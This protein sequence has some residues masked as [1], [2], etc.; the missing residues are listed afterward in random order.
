MRNGEQPPAV[1]VLPAGGTGQPPTGESPLEKPASR[2]YWTLP[3][4][5]VLVILLLFVAATGE[6]GHRDAGPATTPPPLAAIDPQVVDLRSATAPVATTGWDGRASIEG[7]VEVTGV[8][9]YHNGFV[10]VGSDAAGAQAWLSGSGGGWRP[11]PMLETPDGTESRIQKVVERNGTIVA[12]GSVDGAIA[13]WTARRA[14]NWEYHGKVGAMAG[15][16]VVDL[17]AGDQLLAVTVA[18]GTVFEGWT[19]PDGVTWRGIGPIRVGDEMGVIAFGASDDW[20]FAAGTESCDIEPCRP[21]IYRSR[22]ALAWEPTSGLD[23]DAL[24]PEPGA[25]TGISAT[26]N[27]LIAVGSIGTPPSTRLAVWTS[28][29]GAHWTRIAPDEPL[30]RAVAARFDITGLDAGRQATATVA[31]DSGSLRLI[32]GTELVTDAGTARVTDIDDSGVQFVVDGATEVRRPGNAITLTRSPLAWFVAAEGP[33]IV[34]AGYLA[35]ARTRSPVVWSS[36]DSGATWDRAILDSAAPALLEQIATAGSHITLALGTPSAPATAYSEWD[37]TGQEAAAEAT[38][39]AYVAALDD[40]DAA[41]LATLL[42]ARLGSGTAATV[43][44]PALGDVDVAWWDPDTGVPDPAAIR[45]VLA[46][47][48]ALGATVNLE[49]CRATARL[50]GTDS[51]RVVC[52]YEAESELMDALLKGPRTGSFESTIEAGSIRTLSITRSP[53]GA[54]WTLLDAAAVNA[55]TI[56]RATVRAVEPSGE[57]RLQP[58]FTAASAAAHL[59]LAV[60]LMGTALH[61]GE[62]RTV[63]TA[64]GPM[65]WRWSTTDLRFAELIYVDGE[66]VGVDQGDYND[67]SRGPALWA[68]PD[69]S[70]WAELAAPPGVTGLYDLHPFGNGLAAQVWRDDQP[71]LGLFDGSEWSEIP[72]PAPSSEYY[73]YRLA[74]TGDRI[75]VAADSPVSRSAWLVD[76]GHRLE[77]TSLPVGYS[78][79]IL[80]LTATEE[81]FALA[82]PVA[83]SGIVIWY[84]TDGSHWE[85]LVESARL[86]DLQ[87][88]WNLEQHRSRYFVVGQGIESRCVSDDG[89]AT[90]CDQVIRLW[91]SPDGTTWDQVLTSGGESV[92]TSRVASG[93]FGLVAIGEDFYG[94]PPLPRPVYVSV[95][96]VSW[97]RPGNL[98]LFAPDASWWTSTPAVGTSTVVIP[99]DMYDDRAGIATGFLIVGHLLP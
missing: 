85:H 12:L 55:P 15:R 62:T 66:F 11:V 45:D 51:L 57:A 60:N 40:R 3:A 35:G 84:S 48:D 26:G 28:P 19:S 87:S 94:G 73:G 75:L 70:D 72:L 9:G 58:S 77:P 89:S 2:P 61:P 22:D 67:P 27:G 79:G 52:E 24:S 54:M 18:E 39:R 41:T 93:P 30:L 59:R 38:V 53:T 31:T 80:G 46:Y 97:E 23:P 69:G 37:T 47:L 36:A 43:Q 78:G 32:A 25:V 49:S 82:A 20:F 98:T 64:A 8:I 14:S 6:G 95:D 21:V 63:A 96:G 7:A 90:Y 29:D 68:S 5:S 50:G 91:S 74:S 88:L 33:R 34:I 71:Y 42:P 17:L 99:G 81:G 83:S 86:D 92:A 76:D 4:A 1:R 10:A 65:E 56:D 13:S 44:V 16:S